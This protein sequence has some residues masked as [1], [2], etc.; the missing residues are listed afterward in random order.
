MGRSFG[1]LLVLVV[2]ASGPSCRSRT[3]PPTFSPPLP[4]KTIQVPGQPVNAM[5]P[6][7]SRSQK[8]DQPPIVTLPPP[9][10]ADGEI[11]VK[12]IAYVNNVPIFDSELREK[13]MPRLRELEGLSDSERERKLKQIR[14][15]ELEKLIER[16][17][18]LDVAYARLKQM[19]AKIL[20]DLQKEATREFERRI[21]QMKEEYK[22]KTEEQLNDFFAQMGMTVAGFRRSMEREFIAVEF[23][24]NLIFPKLQHIPLSELHSYYV[25][26]PEEFTIPDR[27][28]WLDIFIDAS[29]FPSRTAARQFAEQTLE[30]LRRGADFVRTAN[31]LRQAGY[32]P[33]LG[34]EGVG[35]KP[36]EIR[37][38]EL[39]TAVFALD[40]NQIGGPVEVPGGFH[41]IKVIERT[42][43]GRRPFDAE[44][45]NEI[46]NKLMGALANKEYKR[47]VDDMKSKALIQRLD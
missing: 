47:L 33:L 7:K 30:S 10:L 23:M 19:P 16:E 21:K 27:V 26:H 1:G 44:V 31:E 38:A 42:R 35:E 39:Q 12:V 22:I 40:A 41:L 45:Q 13:L 14:Q 34:P 9:T 46:R 2:F 4:G 20:E 36:G 43:A 37:P 24:R 15:E 29:R 6:T 5:A 11:V 32:N 17:V 3:K 8:P 18:V 25:A 28:K